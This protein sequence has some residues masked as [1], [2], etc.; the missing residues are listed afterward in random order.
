MLLYAG[1][2]LIASA[3]IGIVMERFVL[4]RLEALARHTAW[5]GDEFIITSLKGLSYY[6]CFLAGIYGASLQ[7]PLDGRARDIVGKLVLVAILLLATVLMMRLASGFVLHYAKKAVLPSPSI[8]TLSPL[9]L[10]G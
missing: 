8:L 1:G 9:N 3:I 7:L 2:F 10:D 5:E 4:H 6:S